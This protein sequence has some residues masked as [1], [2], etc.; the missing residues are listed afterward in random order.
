MTG[1]DLKRRLVTVG[2]MLCLALLLPLTGLQAAEPGPRSGAAAVIQPSLRISGVPARE[3]T[4]VDMR[5]DQALEALAASDLDCGDQLPFRPTVSAA[6]YERAK[7]LAETASTV[8]V[9]SP[10]PQE[11]TPAV[12]A[13]VLKT[14]NFEGVN[15]ARACGTCR[16]PDT[17]GAAG[18]SQ[19]VEI[20]NFHV[21][22]YQ[23]ASPNK[24]IKSVSLRTF[25]GYSTKTLFDP[26]V[27]YDSEAKRWIVSAIG[28]PEASGTQKYFIAVSKTASAK[29]SFFIYSLDANTAAMGSQPKDEFDFPQLGMDRNSIIITA[30]I[31]GPGSVFK[32][33]RLLP[34]A[35]SL[36]YNGATLDFPIFNNLEGTLAPPMVLDDNSRTFL[37][38]A[39]PGGNAITL[40]TLRRSNR[41]A[42]AMLTQS[43]ISVPAFAVP[44]SAT[45]PGTS[46]LI[47]TADA[48][49]V[50][51]STQV[52]HSLFQVHTIDVGGRPMPKFYEFNTNSQ[53]VIQSGT[54]AASATSHDWNASIAANKNKD[55][56]VTWTSTDVPALLNAQVRYSGRRAADPLGIIG[57]GLALATSRSFYNPTRTRVERWGDYSAVTIDPRNPNLAWIVNEKIKDTNNW[58]SRIGRIG[59]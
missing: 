28:F 37:V 36:L 23:K 39:P 7:A 22:V 29:G 51:A 54:F 48:R 15:Q 56:F 44:P 52:G 4:D 11:S 14:V 25:F 18:G 10:A 35:K 58:S 26:R 5:R 17:H 19:F 8:E 45:Q 13:P 16:P 3:R 9:P 27:I 38:A 2:G 53:T 55:V 24:R 43:L 33:A 57:S 34:I 42:A 50:T 59:F 6:E 41:P 47:D 49:F 46:S 31:F 21:D 40:Y 1:S 20:T 12:L 32:G 30:N